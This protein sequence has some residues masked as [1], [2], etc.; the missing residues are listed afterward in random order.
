MST[1]LSRLAPGGG[2][3]GI[4][5]MTGDTPVMMADG[6][7]RRLDT[8][9][10]SD[11]IATYANGI[12]AATR[13]KALRSNG[14][15]LVLK[16]TMTSGKIVRANQRH[17]FLSVLPNGCV[18]WVRL[19]NLTS[20]SRIVIVKGSGVNGEPLPA[21]PRGAKHLPRVADYVTSTTGKSTGLQGTD[22]RHTTMTPV[23]AHVSSTGTA[24]PQRI[25]T[26]CTRLKTAV[27]LSVVN[28]LKRVIL[29]L[30]GRRNLPSTTVTTPERLEGC[31][32]TTVTPG[33]D[34]LGM[35]RWHFPPQ[36]I[37]D[38]TLDEIASIEPDG[39][40][41]VFDVQVEHTEN[42][43]ANGLVSHNTWWNEDDW[44]GRIQQLSGM[45][46]ADTFEIVK[47]PAI[48]DQGDE[49]ILP[50]DSIEQLPPGSDIPEGARMTR[51]MNSALHPARYTLA[52]LLKRKATY[53]GLG[54]QRWWHALY[55]QSPTVD[56]GVYFTKK[57]FRFYVNEPHLLERSV[58]QTWDF[59]ITEGQQND[60]TV[61]ATGYQDTSNN[62]HVADI[63]RF[64]SDDSFVIADAILDNWVAHGSCALLGFEDGQIWKAVSAVF[65]RRCEERGLFPSYELMVPL[66]DKA[67]RAQPLRGLMQGGKVWFK[68]KAAWWEVCR[69]EL[70]QF[71]SGG[72]HDDV[73]DSLAWLARLSL[74]HTAPRK[75]EPKPVKS[76]KDGLMA[77]L[78]GIDRS[79]MSA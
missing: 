38:F 30:T 3:L 8:L 65:L 53:Y 50:D 13:I 36:H 27:A 16:I 42:F 71:L 72:K 7:Q 74:K 17:P 37:S 43:I 46:D 76:W 34:T 31:F 29:R 77:R 58:Y 1:A 22:P 12:L 32:A 66:S 39:V 68:D 59:A 56:D 49:Y 35:S 28:T 55:Q 5:C 24:S 57:M 41:E 25:T 19:K 4:M 26:L 69:K 2:V 40:E 67:A 15:D 78:S 6:T 61:G 60:Y 73:V 48:N 75:A 20:T 45:E 33:S 9:K 63:V 18:T 64:K 14:P 54:Q 44:A 11:E 70:T 51:P 62:L 52:S 79:H 47:Y 23:V 10:S 21:L